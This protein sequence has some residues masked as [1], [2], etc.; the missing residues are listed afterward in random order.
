MWNLK[1]ETLIFRTEQIHRHTE[2]TCGCQRGGGVGVRWIES[3]GLAG[4]N[5]YLQDG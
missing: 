2:Q 1:Y 3:L 5:S 4:A